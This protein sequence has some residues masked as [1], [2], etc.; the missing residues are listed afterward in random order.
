MPKAELEA[1][2]LEHLVQRRRHLRVDAGGDPVEHLDD[3][4]LAAEPTPDRPQLQSD[5]AAADHR[6]MAR[7]RRQA[8]GA[9]GG[10]DPPLV[11][12]QV[13]QG[14]RFRSAGDDHRLA[15]LHL[16]SAVRGAHL[17]PVARQQP[18]AA[19]EAGDL[20]L[21]QEV[22]DPF[23]KLGHHLA[24]V[25]HDTVKI[26]PHIVYHDAERFEI[27]RHLQPLGGLEQRLGRNAPDVQAGPPEQFA[28]VDD[29]HRQAEL[30]RPDRT[31]VS[32]R[33]AADDHQV[34]GG[35]R[36]AH[37]VSL[38]CEWMG[39][40]GPGQPEEA[41]SGAPLIEGRVARL[42]SEPASGEGPAGGGSRSPD[43]DPAAGSSGRR[44]GRRRAP[45]APRRS[46]RQGNGDRSPHPHRPGG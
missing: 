7:R 26:G 28:V 41:A 5:V 42:H 17:H 36:T 12:G 19:L 44:A 2:G 1:L 31:R 32:A 20:V 6:Q 35:R 8:Q 29:R 27:A 4:D 21:A 14:R 9:G 43:P 11:D 10:D 33:P 25:P 34:V 45:S 15:G 24:L 22:G 39:E 37:G 13:G 18:P 38:C 40:K 3:R 46:L 23:A 16:E 30:A